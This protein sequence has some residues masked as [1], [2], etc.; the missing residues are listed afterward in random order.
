MEDLLDFSD[1]GVAESAEPLDFSDQG[2]APSDAAPTSDD[3]KPS[4]FSRGF[5]DTLLKQNPEMTAETLEGF[6]YAL[7]ASMQEG[8]RKSADDLRAAAKAPEGYETRSRGFANSLK[9]FEDFGTYVGETA[10][11]GLGSSIPAIVTGA[12]GAGAGQRIAG[13]PGAWVGGLG[14]G[15]FASYGLNY[16]ETYKA[17]KEAG[18]DE[19]RPRAA[20][21]AAYATIPMALLDTVSVGPVIMRLGGIQAVKREVARGIIRRITEEGVKGMTREGVTEAAQEAVKQATISL[22]TDKP[23]WTLETAGQVAEAGIAGV[24][25]GGPMGAVGAVR[26][27]Q[28]DQTP[29][30]PAPEAVNQVPHQGTTGNQP[31][32]P[33]TP[34]VGNPKSAPKGSPKAYPKKGEATPVATPAVD[35]GVSLDQ[36]AALAAS[37]PAATPVST[38]VAPVTIPPQGMPGVT[39]EVTG[40][41]QEL[42]PVSTGGEPAPTPMP[43][44]PVVEE[45]KLDFSDQAVAAPVEA[46]TSP[47]VRKPRI[48]RALDEESNDDAAAQNAQVEKNI[49]AMKPKEVVAKNR[50]KAEKAKRLKE[51]EAADT[52]IKSHEPG[53]AE[54]KFWTGKPAEEAVA[55]AAIKARARQMV[56]KA[57]GLGLTKIPK[58]FAENTDKEMERND[59]QMLLSEAQALLGVKKPTTDDFVRFVTREKTIRAG[60]VEAILGMRSERKS[61][62]EMKKRGAQKAVEAIAAPAPLPTEVETESPPTGSLTAGTKEDIEEDTDAVSEPED[63]GVPEGYKPEAQD[64]QAVKKESDKGGA[65]GL[66][67]SQG[68]ASEVRKVEIT[69]EM[70]AKYNTPGK[71]TPKVTVTPKVAAVK[72]KAEAAK[73]KV[74]GKVDANPTETIKSAAVRV[75]DRVFE[76]T[77][78]KAAANRAAEELG[79]D[80]LPKRPDMDGFTTSTGRF[81]WREEANRIAIKNAQI[82]KA[83]LQINTGRL[84]AEDL[85][86]FARA[87][88]TNPTEAQKEAGNYRKGHIKVQGLDVTIENPKG[89]LRKGKDKG[90][91][92]WSV[93]MPDHYGYIKR[94]EGA[95]G[96]HVDVTV[97]P[98]K[99]SPNVFVIDQVNADTQAFDEHKTFVGFK[100]AAHAVNSY[101]RSFSDGKAKERFGGIRAM[102]PDEFKSWLK[103]G[104]TKNP[105]TDEVTFEGN[106][107]T[108]DFAE[109]QPRRRSVHTE[110]FLK[111]LKELGSRRAAERSKPKETP[112]EEQARQAREDA[113]LAAQDR[114]FDEGDPVNAKEGWTEV[115]TSTQPAAPAIEKGETRVAYARRHATQTGTF[116]S[117]LPNATAI[118]DGAA[119]IDPLAAP[120]RAVLPW[121]TQRIMAIISDVPVLVVP[122][123]VMARM[124]PQHAN[125]GGMHLSSDH[126]IVI[127]ERSANSLRFPRILLHEGI[128]AA[129]VRATAHL[130]EVR[131]M[132][133]IIAREAAKAKIAGYAF[134]NIDEFIA[135]AFSNPEF[136]Q[137]LA[138]TRAS[139]G[140]SMLLAQ[141]S[142]RLIGRPI[143][144]LWEALREVVGR[145]LGLEGS[146]RFTLLDAMMHVGAELEGAAFNGLSGPM[147]RAEGRAR[148]DDRVALWQKEGSPWKK[149]NYKKAPAA[150]PLELEDVTGAG[151]DQVEAFKAWMKRNTVRTLNVHQLRMQFENTVVGEP[152]KVIE[153]AVARMTPM[154]DKF[155]QEY[156]PLAQEFFDYKHGHLNEVQTFTE[157][158]LD[159][160]NL[161]VHVENGTLVVPGKDNVSG[162]Q[163]RGRIGDLQA[164]YDH[165]SPDG[166][167]VFS[168]MSVFYKKAHNTLVSESVKA[169]LQPEIVGSTLSA[170]ELAA[171]TRRALDGQLNEDDR[172]LLG[173]TLYH[174]V[175]KERSFR[176]I[177]GIY[178]PRLRYGNHVVTAEDPVDVEVA[179]SSG[180][181]VQPDGSVLFRNA[182]DT[183]ARAQAQ[184]YVGKKLDVFEERDAKHVLIDR[185]TGKIVTADEATALNDV[186][187][188]YLVYPQTRGVYFFES[189]AA[190][191]KFYRENPQEHAKI[192]KPEA[193]IGEGYHASVFSGTQMSTILRSVDA[194]LP[195]D[196]N[197]GQRAF[198]RSILTQAAAMQMQGNRISSRRLKSRKVAGASHDFD[199]N[200]LNY[201]EAA[202]RHIA[203][204]QAQPMIR[205]GMSDMQAA[206]KGYEGKNRGTLVDAYNELLARFDRAEIASSK[207]PW[208]QDLFALTFI[209]L[210]G[211][212]SYNVVNSTQNLVLGM[213]ILG[214]KFGNV[215]TALEFTKAY[216]DMGVGDALLGGVINTIRAT[217]QWRSLGLTSLEDI[218]AKSRA[219]L[220][221][222]EDG[223]ELQRLIDELTARGGALQ[224]TSGFEVSEGSTL[225]RGMFGRSLAKVDRIVRQVP[226]GVELVNRIGAA[227]TAYRLARRAGY[228]IEKARDFAYDSVIKIHGNYDA[229]VQPRFFNSRALA[230]ALQFKKYSA[231][232]S[233]AV[234]DAA[235]QAF[236]GATVE[237]KRVARKQ[238]ANVVA[239]QIVVV[240]ALGLPGLE[241]IKAGFMIGAAL[242]FSDGWGDQEERLRQLAEDAIG[243]T[244]GELVTSGVLSRAVGVDVSK[245]LSFADLWLAFGEPQWNEGSLR[246]ERESI[247]SWVFNWGAGATGSTVLAMW[248]GWRLAMDGDYAKAAE[249][250]F[251]VKAGTNLIKAVNRYSKGE[252]S[253]GEAVRNAIGFRTPKQADESRVWS[254]RSVLTK[255]YLRSNNAGARAR[256]AAKIRAHNRTA[257]KHLRISIESLNKKRATQ[258]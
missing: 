98:V 40:S 48:L 102:S 42:P 73:V 253:T 94:T 65:R 234:G 11:Q 9:S 131:R 45:T 128:H 212:I 230:P 256:L 14:G 144:N 100:D 124:Y 104:D 158:G 113:E 243:K 210:L 88:D 15:F 92:E 99:D 136:Q 27:D 215:R 95:D 114:T 138:E 146:I 77:T 218:S 147:S 117:M 246:R 185:N 203:N 2:E 160:T 159:L 257:P 258:R 141:D 216:S 222:A 249:K 79:A 60:D 61:E 76:G 69:D 149:P 35:T 20:E 201:G 89:S 83:R 233:Y 67:R 152:L 143:R 172:K 116:A 85:V 71:V 163:A 125:A 224:S 235:H 97:G 93:K 180:G 154:I 174:A 184:D 30:P 239:T 223:V 43:V 157:L 13:R 38:G 122:D 23:F 103:D 205:R 164:A 51:N 33:E 226:K 105:A 21:V 175:D 194:R 183:R 118:A 127:P 139:P 145:A 193:R 110:E 96:D 196:Q 153:Q 188:G 219:Q 52:A 166:K 173:N 81:V 91:K 7:P 240:G 221:T 54:E 150:D 229:P 25:G 168:K 29:T 75:G 179:R 167:R 140:L 86:T 255:D 8:F 56:A 63:A 248:E 132:V 19:D 189:R 37:Q 228:S 28:V 53:P 84:V 227:V 47:E 133:D 70:R 220:A 182:S 187:H 31:K 242:G 236:K 238:L 17:L 186:D 151:N 211:D 217:K 171:V 206:L 244:W 22:E 64:I 12:L 18:L 207:P 39:A 161:G 121:F 68:A 237:E 41:T 126:A 112:E 204:A 176:A 62:G 4:A 10:G 162:W 199:R 155:T 80:A 200:I 26:R 106:E 251:P 142:N 181:S 247:Q 198:L 59:A 197:E 66:D 214:A 252:A 50:T 130:P 90:G 82:S 232:V 109:D 55:R 87:V 245:R 111:S 49:A 120:L 107:V 191:E 34:G 115:G 36:A 16:G 177:K 208:M 78:H 195:G 119:Q 1:Q 169:L 148:D 156:A 165:L 231:V 135:E 190:A 250:M 170:S 241:L 44:T 3:G 129:F 178:F 24:I 202:A 101:E 108:P 58:V 213:P 123:N 57:K 225:S 46:P 6:S 74:N 137:R 5:V 32:P 72:A 209:R 192:N 134:T 254:T